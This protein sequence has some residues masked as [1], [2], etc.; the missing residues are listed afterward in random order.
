MTSQASI[1][2]PVLAQVTSPDREDR[3][4]PDPRSGL[5]DCRQQGRLASAI[6]VVA[7]AAVSPPS[8]GT[9]A[10]LADLSPDPVLRELVDEVL[11]SSASHYGV[12][13]REARGGTGIEVNAERSFYAASLFKLPIM[14]EAFRQ[15]SLGSL[16]LDDILVADW[17][18]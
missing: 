9:P 13:I 4:A 18:T 1:A 17:V 11:G 16:S 10:P 14:V 2:S 7:A 8:I 12:V 3:F 5:S 15:R 6:P